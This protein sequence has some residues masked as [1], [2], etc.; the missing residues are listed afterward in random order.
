MYLQ[1]PVS[2]KRNFSDKAL[3]AKIK[4]DYFHAGFEKYIWSN[5]A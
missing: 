3:N 2:R 4:H 5:I 1:D